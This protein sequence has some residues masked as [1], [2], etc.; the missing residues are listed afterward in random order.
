MPKPLRLPNASEQALLDGLN[1]RLLTDPEDKQRWDELVNS[2]AGPD[3]EVSHPFSPVGFTM[4][5][6]QIAPNL[7]YNLANNWPAQ[8]PSNAP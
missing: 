5:L 6:G 7:S 1:L 4:C 2:K 8:N 3:G